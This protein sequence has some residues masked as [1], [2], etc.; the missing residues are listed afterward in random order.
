MPAPE[1]TTDARLETPR[2][3]GGLDRCG[4]DGRGKGNNVGFRDIKEA[5]IILPSG[6]RGSRDN[7]KPPD[8]VEGPV[9]HVGADWQGGHAEMSASQIVHDCSVADGQ[10]A[11]ALIPGTFV[12]EPAYNYTA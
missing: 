10:V 6:T 8:A 1:G 2:T 12:D 3:D 11:L 5:E 9:P 4:V 7:A